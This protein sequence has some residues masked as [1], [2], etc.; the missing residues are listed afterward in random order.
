MDADPPPNTITWERKGSLYLIQHSD[1]SLFGILQKTATLEDDGVWRC[2][3]S[4][5]SGG[6]H[7]EFT[8]DVLGR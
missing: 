4:S 5:T 1:D 8:V 2:G 7:D 3:A 6:L